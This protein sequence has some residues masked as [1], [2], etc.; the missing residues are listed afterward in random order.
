MNKDIVIITAHC[1]DQ[2]KLDILVECINEVKSQGY[3]IIISTH[4]QVPNNIYEM[5][6]YV[7]YDKENPIIYNHEFSEYEYATTWFWALY[8]GFYQE[9]TFD[10]NHGYAVLK[11]IKNGVSIAK[12]NGYDISHV[13][14]YDYIIKDKNL[15]K[16]HTESL[17]EYDVYSY[18]FK[19]KAVG[20]SAGLFSFKND[21]F[22]ES[23][24]DVN[25]KKDYCKWQCAIFEVFLEKVF[26][27]K[28]SKIFKRDIN[29]IRNDN[30][31]D[32]V[33]NMGNLSKNIINK[34]DKNVALLFLSKIEN[35][36]YIYFISIQ[37]E[38]TLKINM[39]NEDY[40][41]KSSINK[42]NLIPITNEHL[43]SGINIEIPEIGITDFY[44]IES[45]YSKGR[46]DNNN[47]LLKLE[48][49]KI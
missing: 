6:D 14:C 18:D 3:P 17:K 47:I 27:S 5:V 41:L 29:E 25:S 34:N 32:K 23:F 10:F 1:D 42:S 28:S 24:N 37:G 35:D 11:L 31:I 8:D 44:N 43:S 39:C 40:Q 12:I 46:I 16:T 36:S 48:D 45:R 21:K 2:E 30:I 49:I 33:T 22:I 15:L 26:S 20:I 19:V 38:L 7:I 13:V 9:Y 4:I